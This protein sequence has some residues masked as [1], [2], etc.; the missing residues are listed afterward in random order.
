[1][2]FAIK[3]FVGLLALTAIPIGDSTLS[4]SDRKKNKQQ[5]SK[6]A[7]SGGGLE[8]AGD[9]KAGP[10]D[11]TVFDRGLVTADLKHPLKVINNHA[12]Y[13]RHTDLRHFE[14]HV[15][16]YVTPW[17]GGGYDAAKTFGNKLSSVSP[18]W[19]QI[20]PASGTDDDG[21]AIMGAHDIDRKWM[22]EVKRNAAAAS[23]GVKV[24]PRVLFKWTGQ[25]YMQLFREPWRADAIAKK[26]SD[27]VIE[28]Y[29]FDGIVLEVWS[30]LGGQVRP[31]ISDVIAKIGQ[32]VHSCK[33]NK[34]FVLVVPPPIYADDVTGMFDAADL[35][36]LA[37]HVDYFSLMTYDYSSV[38]R[39]GPN[40][41]IKWAKKCVRKLDPQG[42]HRD[43]ILL[44]LNFYGYDFTAAGGG[45]VLGRDFVRLLKE[46]ASGGDATKATV[47]KWDEK[48]EEHLIEFRAKRERHTIF[49]PSLQ[50]IQSR[51]LLA[52]EMK[53]AG[54]AI[55]ELGQGL[56]Y[57]YDLL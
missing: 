36:R 52:K 13:S 23:G 5:P 24:I 34:L 49:Y 19:L 1:M 30:Q 15:L 2:N 21:Y 38:Q 55:W 43:K 8:A 41:P 27:E 6:K 37:E 18:V 26:I 10:L 50:S 35:N 45:P 51:L 25:D 16:G 48:S 14:G 53:L 3:I 54:V 17:N 12:G 57:F 9:L 32:A 7:G 33:G 4:K 20:V 39:P 11:K 56:D 42:L 31:Q 44:G 46:V 29:D 28:K 22:K 47:F 40:S